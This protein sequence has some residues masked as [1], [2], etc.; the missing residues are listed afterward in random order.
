MASSPRSSSSSAPAARRVP[1][2]RRSR[3]RLARIARAAGELCA[4]LGADAVTMEAI[5]ARAETSIGSLY[6]FFPNRDA[7]LNAVAE[8]Y[9]ADLVALLEESDPVPDAERLA[10]DALVDAVLEP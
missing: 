1:T 7:L 9:A 6:Q 3:E 10:L 5:A 2:Q 8:Q 4:E